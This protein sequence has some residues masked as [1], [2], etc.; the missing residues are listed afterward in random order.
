[1]KLHILA[2][3]LFPGPEWQG[4]TELF[5]RSDEE[6]ELVVNRRYTPVR[7]YAFN[8]WM[9]LFA[10]S[11]YYKYCDLGELY[12]KLY[13]QGPYHLQIIGTNRNHAFIRFETILVDTYI[14]TETAEIYI[15]G[16]REYEGIYFIIFEDKNNPVEILSASWMTDRPPVRRNRLAIVI[17]TF[18][19]EKY[20]NKTIAVYEEFMKENSALKDRIK[21]FVVD[22]GKTLDVDRSNAATRIYH[23]MNAGGAGGFTRGLM[24]VC[25]LNEGNEKADPY[26]RCLF[27]DDDIEI[28]PESLYRTLELADYLKGEWKDSFIN[29]AMMNLEKKN[30]FYENL[31]LQKDLW[32]WGYRHNIDI[33]NYDNILSANNIPDEIFKNMDKKACSPWVYHCFS[34]KDEI[35][36]DL[37]IPIFF[38]GDDVEWSWRKQGRHHIS[39]NGVCVWHLS[40]EWKVSQITDYYYLSRNMFMINTLYTKGFRDK[41]ESYFKNIFYYLL[42][43]YNYSSLDLFFR[44]LD[45]ILKGSTGFREDPEKQ[46]Q[47]V[48]QIEKKAEYFDA[49]ESELEKAKHYYPGAGFKRKAISRLTKWGRYWPDFL[50]TKTSIALEW[51]PP[52]DN[53]RLRK[54]VKIFNL[55]TGKYCIRRFDRKLMAHYEKEFYKRLRKI[56]IRYNGL[57]KAYEEAYGEF[58]SFAFWEKYLGIKNNV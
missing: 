15:P 22:N 56:K 39:L 41:F 16:A 12:L 48:S 21:L 25:Y 37:P 50:F 30:M 51:W 52:V 45:D 29:G 31:A 32:V 42:K 27:M 47:E 20:I 55:L 10:A 28:I 3:I 26:T 46:L 24:E 38:R 6:K 9:N 13:V 49:D 35:K 14:T 18:K 17:C 8:T 54:E 19:R 23:N 2:N 33:Y 7:L 58:T 57:K 1:V 4:Y 34:L 43:T 11:K 40:F 44:A 5:V 53:F 36:N